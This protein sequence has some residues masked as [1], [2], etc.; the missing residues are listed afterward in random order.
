[1]VMTRVAVATVAVVPAAVGAEKAR[2]WA[3]ELGRGIGQRLP[4]AWQ[5]CTDM[6]AARNCV[7]GGVRR[8]RG[9]AVGGGAERT[10]IRVRFFPP[11]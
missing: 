7:G 1:M 10:G 3:E 5:Q 2:K 8:G 11:A 6:E 4:S 9:C